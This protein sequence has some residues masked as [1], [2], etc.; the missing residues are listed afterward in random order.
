MAGGVGAGIDSERLL[1]CHRRKCPW[2]GR[3][4]KDHFLDSAGTGA[5]T[6]TVLLP[7]Q[8][9]IVYDGLLNGYHILFGGGT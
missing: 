6:E 5:A 2:C 3:P 9:R 1:L 4:G 7:F 8:D